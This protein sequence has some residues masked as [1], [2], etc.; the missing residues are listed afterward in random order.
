MLTRLLSLAVAC[1][2][3]LITGLSYAQDNTGSSSGHDFSGRT[4]TVALSEHSYPQQYVDSSQ[5]PN[6]IMKELWELW[7]EK[8]QVQVE[9]VPQPWQQTIKSVRE[10]QL[11]FHA[12]LSRIPEREAFLDFS[13]VIY[14]QYS[15]VYI[16]ESI[17]EI[18]DIKQLS[19]YTVGVVA[20]SSHITTVTNMNPKIKLKVFASRVEMYEAALNGELLAFAELE[21]LLEGYERLNELQALFPTYR[22]IN[23]YG[24]DYSAA[25]AKGNIE[26]LNFI[27]EGLAKISVAE[28]QLIANKWMFQK[29]A[30]Q[31]ISLAFSVNL[32]PYMGY[33]STGN[34][35]GL[36]IDI[37]RLW[38]KYS[39]IDVHFV[40]NSMVHGVE[41]VKLGNLDAHLAYPEQDPSSTG[42]AKAAKI[43]ALHSKLYLKNELAKDTS[44][45]K[46]AGKNIGLFKTAPYIDTFK[47][48]FPQANIRYYVGHE[49]MLKAAE[50]GEIDGFVSE[51]ENMQIKLINANMQSQYTMVDEPIFDVDMFTLVPPNN[52]QLADTIQKGFQKIPL[53][54]LKALEKAWLSQ[55]EDAYFSQQK[56][57][58]SLTQKQTQWLL[59]NPEI[60]VGMARDWEP[61]EFFDESGEAQGINKEIIQIIA[62]NVGLNLSFKG[63]ESWAE[64]VRALDS[65][66]IDVIL[67]VSLTEE[68]ESQFDFSDVYWQMPWSILHKQSQG[69]INSIVD[70]Y[71]KQ[72]AFVKGYQLADYVRRNHPKV[73]INVVNTVDEGVVAVEQGLVDGFVE[74]LPVT[75]K[76]A[77]RENIIPLAVSVVDEIPTQDNRIAV[78][79]GEKELMAVINSGLKLIDNTTRQQVFDKWFNVNILTGLDKRFVTKIASLIGVVIVVIVAFVSLWNR[80]LHKEVARRKVLE[81]QMKHLATHDEL[82]GLANRTLMKSQM[83]TAIAQH[84]RQL[85]KLAV[86]FIDLDGFKGINDKFGHDFGDDILKE[87]ATR[88]KG[89]VRKADTVCRFGGDEFVLLL[90]QLHSKE[91][92]AYIAEKIVS[93]IAKTY[94]IDGRLAKLGCSIGVSIF[95]DD[96]DRESDL[97]KM[98]DTLMYRVKSSGKNGYLLRQ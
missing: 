47:K 53:K 73:Q 5:K 21:R 76:L 70:L 93:V 20:G 67:G 41:Q 71:G 62:D 50:L 33:S 25:V 60:V 97:L 63:Y 36:Y 49:N 16:S 59:D 32:P 78:R 4:F 51:I 77:K 22:R 98:A 56:E 46:L 29:K 8:Q 89:C 1:C 12:G 18:T 72:I 83:E 37:W 28:R 3:V 64:L 40:G 17:S 91:E 45:S 15:F 9:F 69:Q 66:E 34:P 82:T 44:E 79:K 80:R 2:L 52:T 38:S 88:I 30:E 75:S 13:Q 85:N 39:N 68:R 96:G 23:Y 27:N 7:A 35:Q 10:R 58:I 95:P 94:D 11:D 54:E 14:P 92:A 90:T 84:Q 61:L 81:S 6:G 19:P 43:Y 65:Q 48:L 31:G 86:L 74:A 57:D 87:V 24:G 42:L 55:P 26:L